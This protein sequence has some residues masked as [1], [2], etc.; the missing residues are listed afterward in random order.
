[1]SEYQYYEFRAIDRPLSE[2]QRKRVSAL[3]SRAHVTSHSAIFVYNY[4]DFRGDPEQLM[5]DSFDAML[6]ISNWGTRRLSRGEPNL[7]ALFN[8]SPVSR[9]PNIFILLQDK[10]RSPH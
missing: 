5:R 1:M 6:Y 10:G 3:P 8:S 4:G 2:E 7:S 9:S